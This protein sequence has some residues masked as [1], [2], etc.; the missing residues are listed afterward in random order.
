MQR[1]PVPQPRAAADHRLSPLR[2]T[3]RW[4]VE[5]AAARQR[6]LE[7]RRRPRVRRLDPGDL[8]AIAVGILLGLCI[9]LVLA[10][11]G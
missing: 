10:N 7:R 5:A 4:E 1:R 2:S 11:G 9:I 8:H 3:E 6:S